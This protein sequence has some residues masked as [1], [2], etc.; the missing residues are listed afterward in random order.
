MTARVLCLMALLAVVLLSG[1]GGGGGVPV[2]IAGNYFPLPIGA[3]WVYNTILEAE[4]QTDNFAT[5]GTMTRTLV[6]TKDMWVGPDLCT[7]FIFR[8][9]YTTNAVPNFGAAS[10]D[11]APFIDH[12]FAAAG[13]LHSVFIYYREVAATADVPAHV[14]MV[15]MARVGEADVRVA[16]PRPYLFIPPYHGTAQDTTLWFTP[17]PLTPFPTELDTMQVNDKVLN[18]GASGGIGGTQNCI[19]S[20]H[21]HGANFQVDGE[22]AAI[23]GRGRTVYKDGVGLWGYDI[24]SDWYATI[25]VG[26]ETSRVTSEIELTSYTPPAP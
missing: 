17:M 22:T 14:E 5:T 9:D 11:V 23:A 6:G 1:C 24:R 19:I 4:T 8:H 20:I 13:G 26:G 12:L 15:G 10:Q 21:Y 2:L 16:I 3:V 25:N 18:Y 7:C